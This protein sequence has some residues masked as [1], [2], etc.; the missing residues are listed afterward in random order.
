MASLAQLPWPQQPS[1]FLCPAWTGVCQGVSTCNLGNEATTLRLPFC[2]PY[3]VC[4]VP[5]NVCRVPL[6]FIP[7]RLPR[8]D[9]PIIP[10][11]LFCVEVLE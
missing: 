9:R 1:Y 2:V 5:Y 4:R 10:A 8:N 7:E 3:N 6:G 11:C